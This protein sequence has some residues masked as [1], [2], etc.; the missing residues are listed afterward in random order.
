MLPKVDLLTIGGL[1]ID[2]LIETDGRMGLAHA[3]GIRACSFFGER[4]IGG[5]ADAGSRHNSGCGPWRKIGQMGRGHFRC[6]WRTDH[7]AP[8]PCTSR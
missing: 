1:T 7:A 6:R 3:S 5:R 2:N 8:A 4:L